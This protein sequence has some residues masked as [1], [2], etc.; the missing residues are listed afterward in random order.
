MRYILQWKQN[1]VHHGG[2]GGQSELDPETELGEINMQSLQLSSTAIFFLTILAFLAKLYV[3][4]CNHAL[5]WSL[6]VPLGKALDHNH[7]RC[8]QINIK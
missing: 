5:L 3:I 2:G 4:I 6:L 1:K 7:T 8:Y